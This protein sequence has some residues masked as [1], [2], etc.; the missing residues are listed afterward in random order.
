[1][2][3]YSKHGKII[4]PKLFDF[5]DM[6]NFSSDVKD[7]LRSVS[8]KKVI[9]TKQNYVTCVKHGAGL[10][11]N[12]DL[13]IWRCPTCH[14]GAYVEYPDIPVVFFNKLRSGF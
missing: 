11:I 8:E 5:V 14:E 9:W 3:N 10:C 2:I 12:D 7:G 13:N 1:M 4:E 6:P